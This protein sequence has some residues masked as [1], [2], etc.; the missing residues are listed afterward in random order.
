M[1]AIKGKMFPFGRESRQVALRH[2]LGRWG[3]HVH[4]VVPALTSRPPPPSP[5]PEPRSHHKIC[6]SVVTATTASAGLQRSPGWNEIRQS[7]DLERLYIPQLAFAL[8]PLLDSAR[9]LV[10][11][12]RPLATIIYWSSSTCG[13]FCARLSGSAVRRSGVVWFRG[14]EAEMRYSSSML[15]PRLVWGSVRVRILQL[16]AMSGTVSLILV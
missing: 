8:Q 5:S 1:E 3:F 14:G 11:Q 10:C 4:P 2:F 16:M 7:Q 13:H 6:N 15:L 9:A 12:A